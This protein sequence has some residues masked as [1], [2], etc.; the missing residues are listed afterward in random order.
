MD[1]EQE[2]KVEP[3][4]EEI[5]AVRAAHPT[6]ELFLLSGTTVDAIAMIP[7]KMETDRFRREIIK[8]EQRATAM[9]TYVRNAIVWPDRKR[10]QDLLNT[11]PWLMEKW[12]SKIE[13]EAGDAEEIETKKL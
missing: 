10:V 11:R 1:K 13:D 9:E 12:Y 5:A 4:E 8:P 3:T 6:R 2:P 7:N